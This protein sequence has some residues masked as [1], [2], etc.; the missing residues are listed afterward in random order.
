MFVLLV[1][2]LDVTELDVSSRV[3]DIQG[4]FA[5]QLTQMLASKQVK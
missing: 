1:R 2:G 4:S 5:Q 3:Q